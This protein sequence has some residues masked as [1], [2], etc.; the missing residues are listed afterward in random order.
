MKKMKQKDESQKSTGRYTR[1]KRIALE[2][3]LVAAAYGT[4][5]LADAVRRDT[6]E[7]N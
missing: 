2:V 3:A 5:K 6:K 4:K 7:T 1:V